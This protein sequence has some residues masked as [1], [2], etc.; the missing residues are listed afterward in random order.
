MKKKYQLMSKRLLMVNEVATGYLLLE[1]DKFQNTL[2]TTLNP[3]DCGGSE[4]LKL[5]QLGEEYER[6]L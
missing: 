3:G 5:I 1:K 2:H 4:N 6:C